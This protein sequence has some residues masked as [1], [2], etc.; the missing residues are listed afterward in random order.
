[1]EDSILWDNVTIERGAIVRQAVLADNVRI[2]AEAIIESA[3]VVRRDIVKEI[4]RGE[5]V[6]EN[7]IIRI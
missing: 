2:P 1:V 4:E 7:L 6:G 3:V 5:V